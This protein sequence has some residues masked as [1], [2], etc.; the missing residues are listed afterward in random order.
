MA[1]VR[2]KWPTLQRG[3]GWPQ[4]G[5]WVWFGQGELG[6]TVG[7]GQAGQGSHSEHLFPSAVPWALPWGP[8]PSQRGGCVSQEEAASAAKLGGLG[9]ERSGPKLAAGRVRASWSRQETDA[10]RMPLSRSSPW[11]GARVPSA[12]APAPQP[13]SL[14]FTAR[15]GAWP[16]PDFVK[17]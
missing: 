4:A 2:C 7:T 1:F 10:L 16:S 6:L 13:G 5:M 14:A 9:T 11:R 8:L 3:E 17:S 12:P 15:A